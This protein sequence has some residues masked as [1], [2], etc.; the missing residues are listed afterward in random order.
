[1]SYE[2]GDRFT[3]KNILKSAAFLGIGGSFA[4]P[5]HIFNW[6][7]YIHEFG[8]FLAAHLIGEKPRMI[9]DDGLK[10][11]IIGDQIQN[12]TG[13]ALSYQDLSSIH[14]AG[15]TVWSSKYQELEEKYVDELVKELEN[16]SAVND[17]QVD[18]ENGHTS[19]YGYSLD[20]TNP[21]FGNIQEKI[22]YYREKIGETSIQK[23][24]QDMFTTPAGIFF[25]SFL[26][27]VLISDGF[28]RIKKGNYKIG[29]LEFGFGIGSPIMNFAKN[30]DT[31][32]I[33]GSDVSDILSN[34]YYFSI[35]S[36]SEPLRNLFGYIHNLPSDLQVYT[37]LGATIGAGVG[38]GY[39]FRELVSF[40]YSKSKK[41]YS[42]LRKNETTSTVNR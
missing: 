33:P 37:V 38:A 42:K 16:S 28:K 9:I 3:K 31:G 40:G 36:D 2:H 12:S 14:S 26:S 6:N 21:D 11:P 35:V 15:A 17:L 19:F 27:G 18:R 41:L 23:H 4:S 10:P 22:S 34:I 13:G 24:W 1:M 30:V 25:E 39:G 29:S 8:H 32:M 5:Y 7:T 20:K